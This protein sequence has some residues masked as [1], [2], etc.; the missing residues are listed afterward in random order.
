[1]FTA[2][3]RWWNWM[4][5][6]PPTSEYDDFFKKEWSP[7]EITRMRNIRAIRENEYARPGAIVFEP[8]ETTRRR[9]EWATLADNT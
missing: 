2:L 1:M 3:R 5:S 7:A 9:R 8:L 6:P 4:S